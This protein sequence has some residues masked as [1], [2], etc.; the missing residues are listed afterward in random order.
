MST[1]SDD[2]KQY[3]DNEFLGHMVAVDNQENTL[4]DG[5]SSGKKKKRHK[6]VKKQTD[7]EYDH[8]D[9]HD[10][11][12]IE[13][14]QKKKVKHSEED[15]Y[16][17]ENDNS[18]HDDDQEEDSNY[19]RKKKKT[20][21]L[22]REKKKKEKKEIK[23]TYFFD[24]VAEESDDEREHI[25]KGEVPEDIM[26]TYEAEANKKIDERKQK[27]N[28]TDVLEERFK[29]V[30]V[31]ADNDVIADDNEQ[32]LM[33]EEEDTNQRLPK[34]EDPKL[35][36]V[37]CRKG[38]ERENVQL[39]LKKYFFNNK[40]FGLKI[41]S[42]FS[43]NALKGYI[44]IE[45]FKEANVREAIA[46]ISNIRNDFIKLIPNNEMTQVLNFDKVEKVDLKSNQWVRIKSGLYEGDLAQI[47]YIQDLSNKIWIKII[48]RMFEN[49]ENMKIGDYSKQAKKSVRPKQQFFNQSIF[50]GG[51]T[52]KHPN[53]N[54]DM[55]LWK[56]KYFSNGFFIKCAKLKSLNFTDIVPKIEE[57]RIFES[58]NNVNRE[59]K[60]FLDSLYSNIGDIT[61]SKNNKYK[62]GE[63]IKLNIGNLKGITGT[64]ISHEA[65]LIRFTPDIEGFENQELE[66]P[67][68]SVIRHF[69]PGDI[70]VVEKDTRHKGKSGIIVE[71]QDDAA[72]IFDESNSTKFKVSVDCL[73]LATKLDKSAV[74]NHEY[75]PFDLVAIVGL[76]QNQFC[77]VLDVQPLSL[78]VMDLK[79]N[80]SQLSIS[81][82]KNIKAK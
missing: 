67:E 26:K 44:Y 23:A 19:E 16:I 13:S 72:Q 48:P 79:G 2:E 49:N 14:K 6:L 62:K 56:N 17:A 29:D 4:T 8:D 46:D 12:V 28:I 63:K 40:A 37:K 25:E 70:V 22:R 10:E 53:I 47:L 50:T 34:P 5:V 75:K 11:D 43:I 36:L 82:V 52:S 55:Y 65:Q 21:N 45:A 66:V 33:G 42:V 20:K 74:V 61:A 31:D 9:V 30:D 54:E 3:N 18:F 24:D 64:V 81:Q 35:W 15:E 78:T 68:N 80:V 60:S 41:F 32:N 38:K 7:F 59:G 51:I 77:L 73:I 58:A 69:L 57:L 1:H 39:L 71:I 27:I 76:T